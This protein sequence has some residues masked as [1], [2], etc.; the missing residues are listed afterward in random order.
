MRKSI[1]SKM[2]HFQQPS[3]VL[4]YLYSI[5]LTKV[6]ASMVNI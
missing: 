4:L 2:S 5:I 3:G 1:K 6:G